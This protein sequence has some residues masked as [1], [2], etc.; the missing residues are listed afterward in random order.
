VAVITV[1]DPSKSR[2]LWTQLLGIAS[3]ASGAGMPEG[4]VE[5]INGIDANRYDYPD[6]VSVFFAIADNDV[7]I[8]SSRS[9]IARSLQAKRSGRSVLDDPAFA[10]G[11]ARLGPATTKAFFAHPGRCARIARGFMS[12]GEVAEIEPV[13]DMMTDTVVSA[14]VNHSDGEFRLSAMVSG[15][16][17]VGE[18]VATKL[19]EEDAK[20]VAS[21]QLGKATKSGQWNKA[22]EIIDGLLAHQS[23][24][25]D[26]LRKKFH[27]LAVG[28]KDREAALALGE[29]L[30]DQANKHATWLNN[31]AW[32]LLT[33]DQYDGKY[34]SLALKFSQRSNEL[35]QHNNWM[36]VDTLARAT[37]DTGNVEEAI[38]L[39]K[40]AIDMSGGAGVDDMNKTLGRMEKALESK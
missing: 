29:V 4:S 28:V 21:A 7:L 39:Q 13:I 31:F 14:L 17:D 22:L 27:I 38:E 32:A 25:L 20:R 15:L 6:H 24:S 10:K 1:N 30:Y 12:P 9:A 19:Q 35:T 40:K 33:E 37:F 34:S 8:T 5:S 18:L 16:P 3:L 36:F 26:L 11:L 23:N 2:A